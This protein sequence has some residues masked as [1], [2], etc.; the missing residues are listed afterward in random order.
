MCN[1]QYSIC[2]MMVKMRVDSGGG[3]GVA[4]VDINGLINMS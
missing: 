4:L 1:G 3:A 2:G